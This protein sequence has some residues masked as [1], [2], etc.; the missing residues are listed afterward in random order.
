[1]NQSENKEFH[2]ILSLLFLVCFLSIV[3]AGY[4]SYSS[5]KE[6]EKYGEMV[7]FIQHDGYVFATEVYRLPA[8]KVVTNI[9]GTED[10]IFLFRNSILS[11][12]EMQGIESIYMK[13]DLFCKA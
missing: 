7:S 10:V 6:I 12:D 2:L 3:L 13:K 4:L 5:Y 9:C 8:K 11:Y 1:M